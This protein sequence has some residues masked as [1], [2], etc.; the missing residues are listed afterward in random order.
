M[1]EGKSE[2]H[3]QVPAIALSAHWHTYPGRFDWILEHGFAVEYSPDPQAFHLLPVHLGA[4]LEAGTPV[5]YHAF[6]PQFELG[7]DDAAAAERA[8]RI[9][10]AA[11]QALQ[12]WGEQVLTVHIG[13]DRQVPIDGQRA[14]ANLRRLAHYAGG[15]GVT[16]ALENL[17]HGPTSDPETVVVW[18]GQAGTMI[19]LDVGHAVSCPRVKAGELQPLDFVHM[20][21]LRLVEAHVYEREASRH[22]PPHDMSVLGPIVDGLLATRCAWWTI[23]LDDLDEALATRSLLLDYLG[24]KGDASGTPAG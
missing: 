16:L 4:L 5:R 22:H 19:T 8:L 21:A 3:G 10:Q 13:L 2:R 1:G 20:F 7:N 12:G 14:V 6:F 24:R 15:L 18:A 9:H 17:R 23:E 11:V